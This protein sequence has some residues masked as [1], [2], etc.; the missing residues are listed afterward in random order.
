MADRLRDFKN[1]ARDTDDARA[2]RRDS[3]I[4]LRKNKRVEQQMKKRQVTAAPEASDDDY[5]EEVANIPAVNAAA[6]IQAPS[7]EAKITVTSAHLPEVIAGIF[8]G[9]AATEYSSTMR[10]RLVH[11]ALKSHCHSD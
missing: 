4:E 7:T 10:C 3:S 8:S 5:E 1:M 2:R 9:D 11:A 6:T